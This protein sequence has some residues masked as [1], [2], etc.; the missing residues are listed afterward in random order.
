MTNIS[1]KLSSN[2]FGRCSCYRKNELVQGIE[3]LSIMLKNKVYPVTITLFPGE[4]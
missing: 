1:E 2:I 3:I 4:P